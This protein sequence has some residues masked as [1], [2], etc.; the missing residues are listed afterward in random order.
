MAFIIVPRVGLA[1]NAAD[2]PARYCY[3]FVDHELRIF[4]R[5]CSQCPGLTL[6]RR[7]DRHMDA[8]NFYEQANIGLIDELAKRLRS[9]PN[10]T[11]LPDYFMQGV[12]R[13]IN[14]A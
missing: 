13:A 11:L 10:L 9:A 5:L 3:R 8:F 2:F 1:N 7:R 12:M 4:F 6:V 14:A